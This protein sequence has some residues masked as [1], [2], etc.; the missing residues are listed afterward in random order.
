MWNV[1]GWASRVVVIIVGDDDV[2]DKNGLDSRVIPHVKNGGCMEMEGISDLGRAAGTM[3][4]SGRG[5]SGRAI[6]ARIVV[7][8][9]LSVA[10]WG[11]ELTL[12]WT[13]SSLPSLDVGDP[14]L[15]PCSHS[16]RSTLLHTP[17]HVLFHYAKAL[18]SSI[19][20]KCSQTLPGPLVIVVT[21]TLFVVIIVPVAEHSFLH[22]ACR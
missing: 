5:G 1:V 22:H 17:Q 12:K 4:V 13:L 6:S 14:I 20:L 16:H 18:L 10:Y 8:L 9:A 7:I 19:S 3:L 21:V 15:L 2:R 11:A